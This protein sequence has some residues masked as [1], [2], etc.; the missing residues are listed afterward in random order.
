MGGRPDRWLPRM[1]PRHDCSATPDFVW[2]NH[3]TETVG[4]AP[5][6]GIQCDEPALQQLG[7]REVFGIVRL[8]P[9][10]P[11]RYAP[12]GLT[13]PAVRPHAHAGSFECGQRATGLFLGDVA[14]PHR[15]VKGGS[16]F[17]PQQRWGDKRLSKELEPF[18]RPACRE[19]DTGVDHQHVQRPSLDRW[20]TRTQ[21]G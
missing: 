18:R 16:D 21:S 13:E 11:A 2:A 1:E 10:E 8:G 4:A 15:L 19:G 14:S 12:R 5:Q 3:V 6:P 7:Q 20:M 17:R 9:A